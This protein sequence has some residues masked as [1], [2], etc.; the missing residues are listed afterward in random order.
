MS[1]FVLATLAFVGVMSIPVLLVAVA[2]STAS[3][4]VR[5]PHPR[6]KAVVHRVIV[7]AR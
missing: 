1:G 4:S 2:E 3:S 7:A 6:A 5:T